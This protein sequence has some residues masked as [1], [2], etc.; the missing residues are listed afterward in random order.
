MENPAPT[1]L[2]SLTHTEA[3]FEALQN[4]HSYPYASSVQMMALPPHGEADYEGHLA[5]A[6]TLLLDNGR[7]E[8][9][10]RKLIERHTTM[11]RTAAQLDES[12]NA[13]PARDQGVVTSRTLTLWVHTAELWRDLE[14]AAGLNKHALGRFKEWNALGPAHFGDD[15]YDLDAMI[16]WAREQGIPY[17]EEREVHYRGT[18]GVVDPTSEHLTLSPDLA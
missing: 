18:T 6:L 15:T 10:A 8:Q 9:D 16:R 3:L 2:D 14:A 17:S 7:S 4:R 1:A 12:P 11:M 5:D 13:E